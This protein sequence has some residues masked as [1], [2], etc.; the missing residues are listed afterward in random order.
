MIKKMIKMWKIYIKCY[1]CSKLKLKV[2]N[3]VKN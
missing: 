3:L 1:I 2:Y